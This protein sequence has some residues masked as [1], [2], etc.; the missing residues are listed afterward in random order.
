MEVASGGLDR[1]QIPCV[2]ILCVRLLQAAAA[3]LG[4]QRRLNMA[5]E[6]AK[7][8]LYL[9]SRVDVVLHR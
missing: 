5:L 7:G 6:A 1:Q 3:E 8:M 4:W 9:H 2:M